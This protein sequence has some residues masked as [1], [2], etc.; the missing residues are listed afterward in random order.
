GDGP[1]DGTAAEGR[2]GLADSVAEDEVRGGGVIEG[3]G[4]FAHL[5]KDSGAAARKTVTCADAREDAVGDGKFGLARGN[6]ATHLGHENNQGSLAQIRRFAAHVR[7]GDEKELLAAGL[8]AEI[9][10]NEA[11]AALVGKFFDHGM[12]VSDDDEFETALE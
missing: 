11:F 1:G 10:R 2:A 7:A 6:K 3:G 5:E 8:Q 12:A 4:D 9:V